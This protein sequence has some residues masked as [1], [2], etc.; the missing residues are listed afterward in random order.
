MGA[1]RN[2][3]AICSPTISTMVRPTGPAPHL[4]AA[5]DAFDVPVI[6]RHSSPLTPARRPTRRRV[7]AARLPWPVVGEVAPQG[8][9]LVSTTWRE[10]LDAAL[11]MGRDPTPWVAWSPQLAWAEVVARRSPLFAYLSRTQAG[12][13]FGS[14]FAIEPN[15]VFLRGTER[16][17]Q[18]AF[19]YRLG[20]TMA[21]WACRGL[22]GLGPTTHAET[23]PPVG[24]GPGWHRA[25]GLPDLTGDHPGYGLTWLIEA[26]GG[27]K[28]GLPQLR[29][30]AQQL[31]HPGMMLASHMRVLS[32]A[33]VEHRLIVTLDIE[34]CRS[35]TSGAQT[36]VERDDKQILDNAR[37]RLLVYYAL[38]ALNQ[39]DRSLLAIGSEVAERASYTG[40]MVALED[41]PS[42][43][44]V[45]SQPGR[46]A[47]VRDGM[48]VGQIPNTDLYVGLSR[49]LYGACQ[50]LAQAQRQL[51]PREDWLASS[52]RRASVWSLDEEQIS[53]RARERTISFFEQV[54]QREPEL[55]AAAHRGF[56]QAGDQDW[57]SV[58]GHRVTSIDSLPGQF[59]EGATADTYLAVDVRSLQ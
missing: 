19:G 34:D 32:G 23:A 24:A 11:R 18:A 43:R 42:T 31:C 54:Q 49:R 21:D 47:S 7:D 27:R 58:L 57:G 30:G 5:K 25:P 45:R 29:K 1:L 39:A 8:D 6:V 13:R 52:Q 2:V 17:A 36:D 3:R 50:A 48:L 35:Q 46:R 56:I 38:S 4:L 26:K 12:S 15:A 33:S 22:M 9:Y 14:G 16:T 20:M 53:E 55:A 59:L 37:S 10:V 28:V 44:A 41:E 40:L 51:L